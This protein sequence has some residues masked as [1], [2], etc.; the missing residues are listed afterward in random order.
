M[1]FQQNDLTTSGQIP[2]MATFNTMNNPNTAFP[3][4][5]YTEAPGIPFNGGLGQNSYNNM[6]PPLLPPATQ[7][8]ASSSWGQYSAD[9]VYTSTPYSQPHRSHSSVSQS[10]GKRSRAVHFNDNDIESNRRSS[11]GHS[12]GDEYY[13]NDNDD[14]SVLYDDYE[15]STN[16]DDT[17]SEEGQASRNRSSRKDDV[18]CPPLFTSATFE[19]LSK[20]FESGARPRP[21]TQQ[22][23]D[24]PSATTA[25]IAESSDLPLL[26][27]R[28]SGGVLHNTYGI[29]GND[30]RDTNKA[31]EFINEDDVTDEWLEKRGKQRSAPQ[32]SGRKIPKRT[33][34]ANDPEN[35]A[36]VNLREQNDMSFQ[37]IT[38]VMNERRTKKGRDPRLTS[39]GVANRYNRTAPLLFA[40]IGMKFVPL[41]QRKKGYQYSEIHWTPEMNKTL[42]RAVKS[43]E[44]SKWDQVAETFN[45]ETGLKMDAATIAAKFITF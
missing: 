16:N 33:C 37:E 24:S 2:P 30:R 23:V 4:S 26:D 22:R 27:S 29:Q 28:W 18:S 31:P 1:D 25:S 12:E 32:G 14:S 17:E 45:A 21:K 13:Q 43:V 38:K 34:G 41:S 19:G 10:S 40:A 11:E 5:E 42:L 9:S 15:R 8:S 20:D 3:N 36:I 35:I 39:T 6:A 7:M 44:A